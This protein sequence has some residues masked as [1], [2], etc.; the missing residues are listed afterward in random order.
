MS[1]GDDALEALGEAYRRSQ[2][3]RRQ[4]IAAAAGMAS[5]AALHQFLARFGISGAASSGHVLA[6]STPSRTEVRFGASVDPV[7][8]G[9]PR[10]EAGLHGL[11]QEINHVNET[12]IIRNER[13][14]A[15]P[16]LAVRWEQ[17][18]PTTLRLSLRRGVRFHNGEVFDAESVKYTVESILAPNSKS[19]WKSQI[20]AIKGVVI[21]D[22]HTV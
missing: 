13:M 8:P 15:A 11:S 16:G 1:Q 6:A 19:I 17:R 22:P 9:D 10:L 20:Q 4:F 7:N 14:G 2:I 12:I 18:D 21:V 5:G 3:S